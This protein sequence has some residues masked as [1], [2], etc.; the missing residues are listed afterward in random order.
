VRGAKDEKETIFRR[1]TANRL[2]RF[3]NRIGYFKFENQRKKESEDF[4]NRSRRRAK[5]EAKWPSMINYEEE[6]SNP[7]SS[8]VQR[9]LL[10]SLHV[11]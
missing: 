2:S 10:L 7:L 6:K 9:I 8:K 4:F 1:L 11:I 5:F 3:G